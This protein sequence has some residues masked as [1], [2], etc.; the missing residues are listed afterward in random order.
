MQEQFAYY[1]DSAS[2]PII[3]V[4]LLDGLGREGSYLL[5]IP[6]A[7][8]AFVVADVHPIGGYWSNVIEAIRYVL[9]NNEYTGCS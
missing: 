4:L 1:G 5:E 8:T 6:F 2:V 7:A 3:H 9:I